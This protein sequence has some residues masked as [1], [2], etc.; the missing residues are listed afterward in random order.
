MIVVYVDDCII[1]LKEKSEID[2]LLE[3]LEKGK[4]MATGKIDKKL[5]SFVFTNDSNVKLFLRIEIEK[6]KLGFNLSQPYLI[7]QILKDL[8]IFDKEYKNYSCETNVS[9]SKLILI[10]DLNGKLLKLP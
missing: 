3:F 8:C 4:D 10:K 9:A 5:R 7:Q 1:L 6:T 2:L